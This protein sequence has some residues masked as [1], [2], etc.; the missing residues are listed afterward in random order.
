[1]IPLQMLHFTG[2][3][4]GAR[5]ATAGPAEMRVPSCLWADRQR[6]GYTDTVE[7]GAGS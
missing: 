5:G 4:W 6:A 1:M 7:Q 2:P 3:L